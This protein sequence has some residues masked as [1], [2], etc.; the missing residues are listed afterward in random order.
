MVVH[1]SRIYEFNS[2]EARDE[3]VPLFM[4]YMASEPVWTTKHLQPVDEKEE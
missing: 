4:A 1:R 2:P 3:H